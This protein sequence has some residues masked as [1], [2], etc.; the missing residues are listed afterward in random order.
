MDDH[1]LS[2]TAA[3]SAPRLHIEAIR[4]AV[5]ANGGKAADRRRR[6][7]K[8][9][10]SI[11][12]FTLG[13]LVPPLQITPED[14]EGGGWVQIFQVKGDKLVKETEW[15]RGYRDMVSKMIATAA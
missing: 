3:C 5:E 12:D 14:H 9:F 2:T 15:F 11:K 6:C 13:G 4:H 8:G 7:K 1:G 10:E